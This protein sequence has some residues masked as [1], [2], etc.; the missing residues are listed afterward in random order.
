MAPLEVISEPRRREILARLG[1]L[2]E[3][4]V[5]ALAELI[6][7]SRPAVSQHLK[8]LKDAGM[9]DEHQQGRQR[10]YRLN[11]EGIANARLEIELFL[12]NE[13]DDLETSARDLST[14]RVTD[15]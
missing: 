5:G 7:I 14:R 13:L 6:D 3:S 4:P 2:G 8:V 1:E 9:V 15:G 11:A 10:L 12:I